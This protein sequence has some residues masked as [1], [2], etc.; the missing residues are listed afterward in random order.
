MSVF[1]R[2][3]QAKS[4]HITYATY[5][6]NNHATRYSVKRSEDASDPP[7][8]VYRTSET[9]RLFMARC[10]TIKAFSSCSS[11]CSYCNEFALGS[12]SST[13]CNHTT[14]NVQ[15]SR[16]L[17][18]G[19]SVNPKLTKECLYIQLVFNLQPTPT[20]AQNAEFIAVRLRLPNER[21]AHPRPR[22]R[23]LTKGGDRLRVQR[24]RLAADLVQPLATEHKR[25]QN[26]HR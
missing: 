10:T 24:N 7:R 1:L 26:D 20:L 16:R 6:V 8:I 3:K 25:R 13:T 4:D 19:K 17:Q 22:A 9:P 15:R 11:Y 23:K 12:F 2:G 14:D 21:S 18:T 5:L